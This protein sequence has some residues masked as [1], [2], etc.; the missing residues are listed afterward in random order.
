M[1]RRSLPELYRGSMTEDDLLDYLVHWAFLR[2]WHVHHDRRSD[3]ARQMGTPG[4]P[5]LVMVR[6]PRVVFAELKSATGTV[7]YE[8]A[9]WLRD[10]RS[11]PGVEVHVW[12][13]ADQ[14]AATEVLR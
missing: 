14:D 10:L 9:A 2:G 11:C 13:P 8:Q 1:T 12:T 7:S 3:L 4:F 6:A 5:D